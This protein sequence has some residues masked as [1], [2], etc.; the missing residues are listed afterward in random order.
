MRNNMVG[1]ATVVTKATLKNRSSGCVH[2]CGKRSVFVMEG[3]RR[4]KRKSDEDQMSERE[5][6]QSS[7]RAR[8]S[9]D[10]EQ[11]DETAP[12]GGPTTNHSPLERE[13]PRVT[14]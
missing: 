5:S 7:V 9:R 4:L 10:R 14:L 11:Q 2:A 13:A 8:I 1:G 12:A 6:R 3:R